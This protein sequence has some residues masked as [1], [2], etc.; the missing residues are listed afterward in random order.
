VVCVLDNR[1]LR[2]QYGRSFIVSLP[3]G[4]P[5]V[6]NVNAIAQFLSAP[7]LTDRVHGI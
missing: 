7:H 6:Q 2:K 3:Q 1:I 5:L 4:I